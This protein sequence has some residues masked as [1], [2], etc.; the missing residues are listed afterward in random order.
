MLPLQKKGAWICWA[1]VN[2]V[3]RT[4]RWAELPCV[5]NPEETRL[6][7]WDPH[8]FQSLCPRNLPSQTFVCCRNDCWW[9]ERTQAA[10]LFV[11]TGFHCTQDLEGSTDTQFPGHSP[12]LSEVTH[13]KSGLF[14][15]SPYLLSSS[16]PGCLPAHRDTIWHQWPLLLGS[17]VSGSLFTKLLSHYSALTKISA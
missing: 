4:G 2:R 13:Q 12:L 3:Q 7:W 11:D 16:S 17:H 8:T 15:D 14:S 10:A 1:W 6:P 5:M 9:E